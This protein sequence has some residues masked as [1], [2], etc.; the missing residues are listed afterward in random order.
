MN[1]AERQAEIN[2][3]IKDAQT[4]TADLTEALKP[5]LDAAGD[6]I[7]DRSAYDEAH[8][9]YGANALDLVKHLATLAGEEGS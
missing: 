8:A 3:L 4:L 5:Y 7:T 6:N 2:Q 1:H 9:D